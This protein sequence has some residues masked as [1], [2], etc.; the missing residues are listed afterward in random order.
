MPLTGKEKTIL[1]MIIAQDDM[2]IAQRMKDY[3]R[4]TDEE[5][6]VEINEYKARQAALIA[7]QRARLTARETEI[8]DGRE[9]AT[10]PEG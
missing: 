8:I 9:A 4:K 6:L 3:E 2:L 10:Q 5:V 7:T 1:R